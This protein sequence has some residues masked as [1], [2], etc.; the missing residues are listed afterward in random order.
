MTWDPDDKER[1]ALHEAGHAVVA[2]SFHV[3]VEGVHLDL[4]TGGGHTDADGE[5]LE[6]VQQIASRLAGYEAEQ[7]FKPPGRKAKA[8]Y[9]FGHVSRILRENET[10][11]DTPEG[12]EL[13]E[14]GRACAEARLREHEVQVRHV[15]HHL[16]EH[17]YIDRVEFEAMM[18]RPECGSSPV[19]EDDVD[20]WIE[21]NIKKWIDEGWDPSEAREEF[22][23]VNGPPLTA[24]DLPSARAELEQ[25][26]RPREFRRRVHGFMKRSRPSEFFGD[27][28]RKFLH[29]AWV[30]AQLS[31]HVEFHQIR[32]NNVKN[33][34]P[35]GYARTESGGEQPI[36]VTVALFPDRRLGDEYKSSEGRTWFE[37]GETWIKRA[38][39]IPAAL[40][41][42][43]SG[44][45][46]K[47]Y[48][49]PFALIVYLNIG[50]YDIRQTETEETIANI[51]KNT[52]HRFSTFGFFG[53]A[54]CSSSKNQSA[55]ALAR[56]PPPRRAQ[57]GT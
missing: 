37:G 38:E 47:Q 33:Q 28:K 40:E 23:T 32:L 26:A 46:K 45:L 4:K 51:K 31:K 56:T 12:Q 10:P 7:V 36:E 53:R 15:A 5:H 50:E 11:E 21:A 34:W 29:D 25:W 44:K 22:E 1:T 14:R 55:V 35:D 54:K 49:S 16:I 30:L 3:R 20:R 18:S 19:S 24:A 39:S 43:V 17:H 13:R 27:P 2:W 48:A 8:M 6:P 52:A 57:R 42:A 9:D 41:K